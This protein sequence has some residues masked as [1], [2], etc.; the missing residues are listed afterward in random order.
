[1]KAKDEELLCARHE[2]DESR[3]K[4]D[5]LGKRSDKRTSELRQSNERLLHEMAEHESTEAALRA[6]EE[7]FRTIY[8]QSPIAIAF[9]DAQGRLVDV[10]RACLD[11]FGVVDFDQVRGLGLFDTP[12][13]PGTA[14]QKID[15]GA[16]VRHE[17][18][19]DFAR[20]TQ[21]GL[22]RTTRTGHI[23]LDVL[24]C[25]L[26]TTGSKG[27][28]GYLV[29]VQDITMRKE[30]EEALRLSE[31][32]FREIYENAPVMMH[33]INEQ[34][35]L[36]NVNRK[37]SEE[38]GYTRE[39]AI[40]RKLDLIMTPESAQQ[41]FTKVL[42][43]YWRDGKVTDIPYQY[44]KRDGTVI[45][46][47][48][49][50]RVMQ[51]PAWGAIS[52]SVIRDVTARKQAEESLRR[53]EERFRA[54]FEGARDCIYIKDRSLRYT[55]VNPAAEKFMGRPASEVVGHRAD[56][57]FKE[58]TAKTIRDVDL[59]VLGGEAIEHELTREVRGVRFTF[60]EARVPLWNAQSEI[61]GLCCMSRD[62]TERKETEPAP[63]VRIED[64]AAEAM[65]LAMA[66]ARYAAATD[67]I[68]LL[69]GESGSG[70][71]YLARWIHNHSRRATGPFFAVNCAAVHHELAESELFGHEAG[72]FTGARGRKRGL[73]ELAEGGTLLLN[74]IGELPIALQSKLLTFLDTRSFLRVGGEKNITVNARLIAATHRDLEKEADQGRFLRALFYRLNVFSLEVPPLRERIE[75]IPV[76]V[77][78]IVSQLAVEMQL[79]RIPSIDER[80]FSE[81][82]GYHWPGNIRELRNVLERALMV[83]QGEKLDLMLPS[84]RRNSGTWSYRLN[85]PDD[86]T[87]HDVTGEVT[88]W[89]CEE[90]LRRSGG[91]KKQAAVLLGVSRYSLYRYLKG[92]GIECGT[93]TPE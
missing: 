57:I 26:K 87:L 13:L 29:Q 77:Q 25:P 31:A 1:M 81:L 38:L 80:E 71:D 74:E 24:I 79:T 53:S 65:R 21:R 86:R 20:A 68:V 84:S 5:D 58:E 49:S 55:H 89:L 41:A 70:K 83:S 3:N 8:E 50:S 19:F 2:L 12:G 4:Y 18:C 7:R 40:G 82:A 34:G 6:S 30:A 10:N 37:W 88:R 64:Y 9:F 93:V 60:H 91:N 56:D 36:L 22:Y 54:V 11:L 78:Q 72:A 48:L 45:D 85:F 32:R 33:S 73:L 52:L 42:P 35:V 39:E 14:K 23:F 62:I 67:S 43:R 63:R 76:M 27:L 15:R 59:R 47:L 75:D 69:L 51:D 92:C 17:V 61:I 44:V 66:K 46:V 90:A 28:R 16:T